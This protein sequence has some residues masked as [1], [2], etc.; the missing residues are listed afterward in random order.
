MDVFDLVAKLSLDTSGYEQGLKGAKTSAEN[1]LSSASKVLG[2]L[3]Q[4]VNAVLKV[5]AAA[6]GAAVAGMTAFAKASVQTGM[7]FDSAMSQ[8]A[9]TMGTT[10]DQIGDLRA[11]AQEMGASTAFSATQAAEALN[12]M[13]LA[14]Y[15]AD[16]SMATLPTVLNLAAAGSMDLATASD[17]VTDAQS[18][19]GLTMSQTTDMVDQMAAAASKSNTS[20]SQLGEA[21]LTI[22]ATARKMKGGTV[23]LSTILGV[24]A[25]NGIKGAEGGTHLRNMMLSL[26]NPTKEATKSLKELGV[27]VYDSNGDMR[28][29][30]DIFGDLQSGLAKIDDASVKDSLIFSIFN[31]TDFASVNALLGTSTDRFDELTNAILNSKGAAEAMADTQLDNLNGDIT[32]MKSA[33]EGA[34]IA[35]SDGLTPAIRDVVQSVTAF[36]SKKSTQQ[37]LQDVGSKIGELAKTITNKL[38]I[39]LPRLATLFEDGGKKLKVFGTIAAGVIITIKAATNPI[40]ALVTALGLL[41]GA[42]ALAAL[43]ADDLKQQYSSLSDEQYKQVENT[44]DAI[45]AYED[46]E[47]SRAR[48]NAAIDDETNKVQDLWTE[49]Q[50][51]VDENGKVIEG[52]EDH[53]ASIKT[54]L[55]G[56]LG[57]EINMVDGVIDKYEELKSAIQE[58]IEM[59][60]AEKKL[61]AAEEG[62]DAAKSSLEGISEAIYNVNSEIAS[63]KEALAGYEAQLAALPSSTGGSGGLGGGVGIDVQRSALEDKIRAEKNAIAEYEADLATLTSAE[64]TAYETIAN[65]E[66]AEVALMEKNYEK[67]NDILDNDA[68]RRAQHAVEMGNI[69]QT[70][71]ADLARNADIALAELDRY[72]QH[73]A[74]GDTGY[75]QA[76]F[77][78]MVSAVDDMLA[79]LQEGQEQLAAQGVNSGEEYTA[80][81]TEGLDGTS[82]A[83][84]T[85]LDATISAML[86]KVAQFKSAGATDA[87]AYVKGFNDSMKGLKYPTYSNGTITWNYAAKGNDFVPYDN[88]PAMLHRGEA[89]LTA[90]EAEEWRKGNGSGGNVININQTIETVPQTPVELASATAAYFEQ[91]RWAI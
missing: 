91:A 9:A 1:N 49:L 45:A 42:S 29:M 77:D 38:M 36:L 88:Y 25:D 10:V 84:E 72:Q 86:S 33:L 58:A 64:A 55:E 82:G 75:T 6:A 2:K 31:R 35:L 83:A 80:G 69:S 41:A 43:T 51:L 47:D 46:L 18:A 74:A 16:T 81:I 4:G 26:Q 44:L 61:A 63:A 32:L 50:S 39:A 12:Y 3:N 48:Q 37:F 23:E 24:L 90:R 57:I 30:V 7:E 66:E 19:L 65:Y 34:K 11:F 89:V 15:D 52:N 14:G 68:L 8:V 53:A 71:L 87:S 13:A 59:R 70:E 40:G 56:A 67:V 27:S 60:R 22:G 28:S 21:F 85:E 78:K 5:G 62:Y 79:V 76:E 20:V 54:Q 73:L 17:M